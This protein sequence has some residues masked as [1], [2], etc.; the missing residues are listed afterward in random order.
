[1]RL[2]FLGSPSFAV[3]VLDALVAH[4][5]DVANGRHAS[6]A[7]RGRGKD[8]SPTP[9]KAAAARL[10]IPAT[11]DVTDLVAADVALG[12]V[13]AYGALVPR[14][15][16]TSSDAQPALLAPAAVA[17]RGAA[18]AGDPGGR[19]AHRGVR[20][21]ARGDPRH[22]SDLRVREVEVDDKGSR[23]CAT[24]SSPSAPTCS[25]RCSTAGSTGCPRR[26]PGG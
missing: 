5:H 20:D 17:G 10:G 16:S 4:G 19:R 1:M 6:D 15:C 9:V 22:R 3:P 25:A 12:V 8:T 2:G 23:C 21:G 26:D 14:R 11:S 18:R 7:R 13:V 24:S